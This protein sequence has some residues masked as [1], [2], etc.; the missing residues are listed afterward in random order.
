MLKGRW[1]RRTVRGLSV[2]LA[3]VVL[4]GVARLGQVAWQSQ[5]F[6][7]RHPYLQRL[8]PTQ[9][10]IRWETAEESEGKVRYGLDSRLEHTAGERRGT[11]HEVVLD[12]LRPGTRYYYAA[13][14]HE[15]AAFDTPPPAGSDVPVRLWALGDSGQ[16]GEG[17][18]NVRD[19]ALR[20][21]EAHPR[22]ER[23]LF[24]AGLALG[25]N[26]YRSGSNP[27]YQAAYFEPLENILKSFMVWPAY[28]NHDA[29]RWA[30]FKI[31]TLPENGE[32]GGV[33]SGTEH[34]YAFDH[35]PVHV[36]VLDSEASNR[37]SDGRMLQWLREDLAANRLPWLIAV[38]HHP[39]Y[40]KAGHRSD[41][42]GDS[43]GRM[44]DMRENALPILEAGGVDLVLSGHSHSYERSHLLDCHYGTSDT[45]APGMILMRG[46]DGAV[47]EKASA[48]RSAHEG[49][50]YVVAGSSSKLDSP[51]FGHPVM[52][53]SQRRLGSVVIDVAGNRLDARFIDDEGTVRDSFAIVKGG[54]TAR[55]SLCR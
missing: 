31:L 3:V 2:F 41:D 13:G 34:W 48:G 16:I 26:A 42:P 22:G 43:G 50:V 39:P 53:T 55:P 37:A 10:T 14:A 29:R 20:W 51:Q 30:Y 49:A 36:V 52:A 12:G 21:M 44:R 15:P 19:A 35:G 5:Y 27:Q 4:W 18:L 28:G 32:A 9:V 23:P 45:L 33:P 54:G 24:D 25:D 46:G 40:T 6:G 1:A 38:M 47:F 8:A 17:L 7:D 11:N